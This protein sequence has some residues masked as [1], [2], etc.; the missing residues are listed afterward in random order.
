MSETW[1]LALFGAFGAI[2]P[3]VVS[4]AQKTETFTFAIR[5]ESFVATAIYVAAAAVMAVI[6]PYGRR[7]TPFNAVLVG[8]VFPSIVGGAFS[9]AKRALPVNLPDSLRGPETASTIGRWIDAFSF[10]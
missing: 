8:I 2:L 5:P 10:M 4:L 1:Y 9:I 3:S 7:P 6:F